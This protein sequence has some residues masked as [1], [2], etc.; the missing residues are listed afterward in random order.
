MKIDDLKLFLSV[1]ELGGF[2]SAADAL[3]IPRS[4]VSRRIKDLEDELNVKLL[5]RTTRR[6]TMTSVGLEYYNSLQNIIPML[7]HTHE[8]I[9]TQSHEPTGNI[10]IGLLNESDIFIHD[11]LKRFL[12]KYPKINIELHL[13]SVGY[14]DIFN[15][16]LDASIHIGVVNDGSFVARPIMPFT[17]KLYA[18][19]H[20]IERHGRPKSLEDLHQHNVLTLRLPDGQLDNRLIFNRGEVVI[21]SRVISNSSYY[22]RHAVFQGDGIGILPEII[23]KSF[24]ESGELIDLLPEYETTLDNI[25]LVYPGKKGLS[26][27][28]RLFID[29]I[30]AEMASILPEQKPR[31]VAVRAPRE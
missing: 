11:L 15:Y 21:H 12:E 7:D 28:A 10:K 20:Y 22:I 29:Y 25:W 1:V 14:R 4:N 16:G 27:A 8:Q 31:Q 30:L 5:T 23:V 26:Y 6:L 19:P 13:S 18:T 17:R 9:R 24:V 3:N 2:T